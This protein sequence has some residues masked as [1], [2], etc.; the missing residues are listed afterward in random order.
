MISKH[1][2]LENEENEENNQNTPKN[3]EISISPEVATMKGEIG[4]SSPFLKDD[5]QGTKKPVSISNNN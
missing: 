4:F 3:N 5:E 2:K 1:E